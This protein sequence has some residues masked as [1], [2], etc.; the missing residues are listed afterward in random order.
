MTP[1][2]PISLLFLFLSS[3]HSSIPSFALAQKYK[4]GIPLTDYLASE[5]LDGVR[6]YWDGKNLYSR[7]GKKFYPPKEFVK[8][9]PPKHLDGELWIPHGSFEEI[10]SIVRKKNP[11]SLWYKIRFMVFD[12]PQHQGIFS[13]RYEKLQFV[14]K[15]SSSPH[16]DFVRQFEMRDN[17]ELW[18]KVRE[19]VRLGGEGI[20]LRKKSEIYQNGRI[21][22]LLKAKLFEDAEAVVLA[23]RLGKGKFSNSLG[24]MQVRGEKGIIFWIGT[25]FT[26]LERKAPPK[27]GERITYRYSGRTKSGIPRFPVFLRIRNDEPLPQEN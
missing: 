27:I 21:S 3:L 24:S 6:S 23:H 7:G 10:S 13:E 25:G 20:M 4:E 9:F 5:K 15:N 22:T 16:L 1:F 12:L 19:I 8:H 11:H 18:K 17:E 14:V 2:L 26:D